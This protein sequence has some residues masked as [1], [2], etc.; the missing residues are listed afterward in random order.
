MTDA[1]KKTKQSNASLRLG[2]AGKVKGTQSIRRALTILRTVALHGSK[3]VHLAQLVRETGI[4]R[5]TAHRILRA[6]I[7]EQFVYRDNTNNYYL[8]A[9]AIFMISLLPNPVPLVEFFMP[10]LKKITKETGET[11]FLMMYQGDHLFCLHRE[12]G[13][14]EIRILTTHRGQR[15]ALGAGTAGVAIFEYLTDEEI[16]DVYYRNNHEYI[17]LGIH[18]RTLLQQAKAVRRKKY[19]VVKESFQEIG[20]TG[21][22]VAFRYGNLG[23]GAIS[24]A[25]LT[26]SLTSK[27]KK[28]LIATITKELE[29]LSLR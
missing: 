24:I 10:A 16:T 2:G 7:D 14:A 28:Q 20:T 3:G 29:G 22:G 4:N 17:K 13:N 26:F 8:G 1:Q 23:L 12:E 15:R 11:T 19:A 21:L 27:R 6:L 9:E 25:T 18:L 5:G